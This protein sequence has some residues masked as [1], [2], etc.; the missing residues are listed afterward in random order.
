MALTP[1]AGVVGVLLVIKAGLLIA[2]A[3]EL[4][5]PDA[6]PPLQK[7]RIAE[8][9][10]SARGY[11]LGLHVTTADSVLRSQLEL[12]ETG[13]V[14]RNVSPGSPANLAGLQRDDLLLDAVAAGS[15]VPLAT[16]RHLE[17]VLA[18]AVIHESP[19]RL[20]LLR[21]GQVQE[22]DVLPAERPGIRFGLGAAAKAD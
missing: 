6:L 21:G 17:A 2:G 3:L 7:P 22:V 10:A 4:Q 9:R 8:G 18:T 16:R 15:T 12:G 14:V 5:G 1:H 11:W 19:I 13:L 20:R